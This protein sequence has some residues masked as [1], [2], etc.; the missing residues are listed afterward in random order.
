M[1]APLI[2]IILLLGFLPN[3]ALGVIEPTAQQA[4]IQVKVTDPVAP[5]GEEAK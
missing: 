3:I 5:L 4:M 2:A 1:A